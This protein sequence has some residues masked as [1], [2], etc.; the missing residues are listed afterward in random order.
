MQL[1]T[2][3]NW[4]KGRNPNEIFNNGMQHSAIKIKICKKVHNFEI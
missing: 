1:K 3:R 2:I 4:R